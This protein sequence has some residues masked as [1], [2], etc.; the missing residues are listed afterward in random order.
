MG[1]YYSAQRIR[2]HHKK[3]NAGIDPDM[4]GR[5]SIEIFNG[6]FKMSKNI[7]IVGTLNGHAQYD[8]CS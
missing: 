8:M 5:N 3:I 4:Q 2:A 1:Y 6:A 7:I